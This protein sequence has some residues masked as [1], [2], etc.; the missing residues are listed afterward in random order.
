MKHHIATPALIIRDDRLLLGRKSRKGAD[1]G[2]GTLNGSGG[3]KEEHQTLLECLY[4]VV[5]N[6]LGIK[7]FC[8]E[9][10]SGMF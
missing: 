3:K 2:E 8:H 7:N 10:Q 1:I 4:E 6:E 9:H 5:H